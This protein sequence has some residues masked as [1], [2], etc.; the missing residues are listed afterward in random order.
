MNK[1]VSRTL[2]IPLICI[3][4]TPVV[5]SATFAPSTSLAAP[6]PVTSGAFGSLVALS[7]SGQTA[8]VAA[9]NGTGQPGVIFIYNLE[10]GTW[11]EVAGLDD[12]GG[13]ASDTFGYAI[14]LSGDGLT[15]IACAPGAHKGYIYSRTSGTWML[16]QTLLDPNTTTQ[17]DFCASA[18]AS[19]DGTIILLGAPFAA[20]NG[21]TN[22]GVVYSY[23]A[24]GGSWG[25]PTLITE[26]NGAA[27]NDIFGDAIAMTSDGHAALIGA[28]GA[29]VGGYAY[30][31]KAYLL[32]NTG[33]GAWSLSHEFDNPAP[34]NPSDDF[35]QQVAVSDTGNVVLV[36]APFV[37]NYAGKAFIFVN[38]NGV[39]GKATPFT[40][41]LSAQSEQFGGGVALSAD[42]STAWITAPGAVVNT[43][44]RSGKAFLTTYSN[45]GWSPLTEF[46]DPQAA[47]GDLFGLIAMSRDGSTTA[48]GAQGTTV[49][50][51]TGAG[52]VY[53]YT[54]TTQ[55]S[56]SSGGSGSTG[57]GSSGGGGGCFDWLTLSLLAVSFGLRRRRP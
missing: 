38:A 14:A 18:G 34:D 48:I 26:P 9:T 46:D 45:G 32:S 43:A 55:S 12:P 21:L 37:Q 41:P 47:S 27:A 16:A 29:T 22:A 31:G 39:W 36:G 1:F 8:L 13:S 25:T 44:A 54:Q 50:G 52:K 19:S 2:L 42:G 6:I 11:K 57:S 23:L 5:Y 20:V 51:Q 35:G 3:L 49:N 7:T 56:G 30:A 24:Q 15:A 17:D 53:F 28:D 33:S 4:W 40:D 10:N